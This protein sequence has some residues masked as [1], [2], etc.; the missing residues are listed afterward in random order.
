MRRRVPALARAYGAAATR[1]DGDSALEALNGLFRSHCPE[2][3]DAM[4][5]ALD[6]NG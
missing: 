5:E 6:A 4:R 1:A 2:S 3:K